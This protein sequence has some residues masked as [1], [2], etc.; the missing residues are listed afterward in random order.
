MLR[1]ALPLCVLVL[2]LTAPPARAGTWLRPVDGP[3][4]RAFALGRDPWA[5][6]WHRGADLAGARGSPVRS[7]CRGRVSF[8]GRV[9]GGGKTVS[10]RCGRIVA[11]YQQLGSI[12]ALA[13]SLVGRGARLGTVGPSSDPRE[14]RAHLHLGARDAATGRYLDPLG[15]LGGEG[16]VVV[17]RAPAAR[18]PP[19]AA[20][21]APAPAPPR[22]AP[23][24]PVPASP[25][26]APV[27]PVPASPRLAPVRPGPAPA[28]P[29]LA[30]V[31]PVPASRWLAPSPRLGPIRPAPAP[32][33]HPPADST[34][35]PPRAAAP[36]FEPR[37]PWIAWIGLACA[38]LGLPIGG[39]VRLRRRRHATSRVE[40][41][42]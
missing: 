18:N 25:R 14:R 34:A 19:R 13:G 29:R 4:L 11:T 30:P 40:R 32:A 23:I 42:A 31:R 6:G 20:P 41:T 36:G 17:P 2:L 37:V 24:R 7:A 3:V 27:R 38:G 21:L 16:P 39:F 15:L 28:S 26:I 9:P 12:A 35:D 1:F 5:G 8:A 33:S 10:V 22:L